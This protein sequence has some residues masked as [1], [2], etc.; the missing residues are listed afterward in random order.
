M[1]LYPDLSTEID[2]RSY[3]RT[4]LDAGLIKEIGNN[5]VLCRNTHRTVVDDDY[6]C[7]HFNLISCSSASDD[8]NEEIGRRH[9]EVTY[10]HGLAQSILSRW[11]VGEIPDKFFVFCKFVIADY[12]AVTTS[13]I[14]LPTNQQLKAV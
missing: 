12:R 5:R 11:G 4:E 2:L 6:Q 7:W 8:L 14:A 1:T 3:C 13:F 9:T 10:G